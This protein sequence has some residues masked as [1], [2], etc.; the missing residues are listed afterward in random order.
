[1]LLNS[2][3]RLLLNSSSETRTS[4]VRKEVNISLGQQDCC[5]PMLQQNC[6]LCALT[7][8]YHDTLPCS[9]GSLPQKACTSICSLAV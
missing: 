6:C 2:G 3:G 7:D 5:H 1:M 4:H 9:R 8:S